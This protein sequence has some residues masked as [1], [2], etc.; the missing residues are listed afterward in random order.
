M[1]LKLLSL[2]LVLSLIFNINCLET[3]AVSTK[4]FTEENIAVINNEVIEDENIDIHEE[5]SWDEVKLW[6]DI[7]EDMTYERWWQGAPEA[8]KIKLPEKPKKVNLGTFRITYY[9]GCYSCSEGWGNMTATGKR[10]KEGRTIAVD[11]KVIP[12]GTKVSINGHTYVAEDCGGAIKGND[13][14]IYLE[15]HARVYKG[16]VDWYDVYVIR[17]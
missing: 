7:Y 4:T 8:P 16:G 15:D 14:D 11:P 3:N 5:V 10:A 12:Y 17:E 1:K 13:I 9:C 6:N 2:L